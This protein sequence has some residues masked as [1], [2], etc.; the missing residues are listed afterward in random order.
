MDEDR[1]LRAMVHE[2]TAVVYISTASNEEIKSDF[3]PACITML[4]YYRATKPNL[5][6]VIHCVIVKTKFGSV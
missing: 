1:T 5:Q 2:I 4:I 3:I 6:P